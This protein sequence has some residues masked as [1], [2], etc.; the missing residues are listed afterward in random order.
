MLFDIA[1]VSAALTCAL[2][3]G[4]LLG[5]AVVAMPGLGTLDDREYVRAFQVM[6]RV[7]Q[8]RQPLFMLIWV[9]SVLT[10]VTAAVVGLSEL[11]GTQ[12]LLLLAAT[13]IY[14][15]GV[16]AP[17]A[18]INVPLNNEIQKVDVDAVGSEGVKVARERFEARWNRWNSIRTALGCVTSLA[19]LVLLLWR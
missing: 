15:L 3:S 18:A 2:V 9:G 5:F 11:A 16:Q 7:I 8:D 13:A 1:L 12:R 6:D 19:L 14:L 10:L 4:F 17:T